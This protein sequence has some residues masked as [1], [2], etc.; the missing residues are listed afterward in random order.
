MV[1]DF[2]DQDLDEDAAVADAGMSRRRTP[3]SRRSNSASMR[4]WKLS[5]NKERL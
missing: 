5:N 2:D 1:A 3:P 4:P